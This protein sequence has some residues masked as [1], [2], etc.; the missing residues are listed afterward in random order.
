VE[1]V[2]P[3]SWGVGIGVWGCSGVLAQCIHM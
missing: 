1:Q 2:L 3:D